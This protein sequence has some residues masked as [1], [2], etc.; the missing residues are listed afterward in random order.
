MSP[1]G[2]EEAKRREEEEA[3]ELHERNARQQ[4]WAREQE[5]QA[6]R[7]YEQAKMELGALRQYWNAPAAE[8]G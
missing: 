7:G 2:L 1:V 5:E 3:R 8:K 4:E 6:L